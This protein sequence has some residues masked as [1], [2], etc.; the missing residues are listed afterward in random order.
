MLP[1]TARLKSN[2][3]LKQ[4]LYLPT[5]KRNTPNQ[6]LTN[7]NDFYKPSTKQPALRLPDDCSVEI[8]PSK[9]RPATSE[10]KITIKLRD[11]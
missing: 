2:S 4:T 7:L 1:D 3:N 11:L 10:S 9:D 6:I 5:R 8:Q